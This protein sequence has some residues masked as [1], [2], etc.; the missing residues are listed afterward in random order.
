MN[1]IDLLKNDHDYVDMLFGRIEDTPPSRHAAI[2]KQVKAELETHAHIEESIFYPAA[3]AK[4]D[5]ELKDIVMEALEEHAQIK[6]FLTEIGG[7]RST[8]KREAQLKVLIEDTRHHVK[9]EENEMFPLV[10]DQLGS[11]QLETLGERMEAEKLKFQKEN[12]IPARREE[13][14]GAFTK[15]VE[16]AKAVVASVMPGMSDE[17]NSKTKKAPA[18]RVPGKAASAKAKGNPSSNGKARSA[19]G[20]SKTSSKSASNGKSKSAN[21]SSKARSSSSKTKSTSP[22]KSSGSRASASR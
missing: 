20:A 5:K 22:R 3:K 17:P 12:G 9:E 11:D 21:G 13:P 7:S 16:K 15:V 4:G 2:F 1:A 14:Q 8:D 10:E 18:K 19:N 6:M